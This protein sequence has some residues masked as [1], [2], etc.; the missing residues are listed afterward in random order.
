MELYVFTELDQNYQEANVQLFMKTSRYFE[1]QRMERLLI[2]VVWSCL[3]GLGGCSGWK[4]C[5]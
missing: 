2:Q 1:E 4:I 3:T 5:L